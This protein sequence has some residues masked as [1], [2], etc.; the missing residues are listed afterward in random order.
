VV[1][2]SVK[3]ANIVLVALLAPTIAGA[4]TV[5][6]SGL[7][8]K[9]LM[10]LPRET[11]TSLTIWLD[12]FLTD[13]EQPRLVDFDKIKLKAEKLAFYCA[14]NPRV[15]LLTAAEDVMEK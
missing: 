10:E 11:V 6:I 12:G 7:K 3:I 2:K 9:D 1:G 14:Q 13:D 4:Q 15:S 5:D 8:C